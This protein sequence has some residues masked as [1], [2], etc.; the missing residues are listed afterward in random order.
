MRQGQSRE[1]LQSR[2]ARSSAQGIIIRILERTNKKFIKPFEKVFKAFEAVTDIPAAMKEINYDDKMREPYWKQT[3]RN[4]AKHHKDAPPDSLTSGDLLAI[5]GGG[6]AL[7][8]CK[9]P[10]GVTVHKVP[11]I[12]GLL[13]AKK[14]VKKKVVKKKETADLD[15]EENR[16][17][18]KRK[19]ENPIKNNETWVL[20]P[21][22]SRDDVKRKVERLTNQVRNI[23]KHLDP[24]LRDDVVIEIADRIDNGEWT[25]ME[26]ET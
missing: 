14:V 11:I 24:R 19:R 12:K 8:G 6:F 23:V 21:R 22:L 10:K 18:K 3:V 7:P 2:N 16:G 26:E 25:F 1:R 15:L 20:M 13:G 9:L 17:N 5:K 4:A